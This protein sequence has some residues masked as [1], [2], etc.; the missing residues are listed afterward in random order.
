MVRV[1]AGKARGRKLRTIDSDSTKP[2]LD[3]VKEAMFSMIMPYL[4]C[5]DV[6]DLF[7]GNGALGIEALSR[8]ADRCVFNDKSR[9]CGRYIKEN[10]S[11]TGFE[12]ASEIHSADYREVIALLKKKKRKF[13]LILLDPPYG[14]EL[15][16]DALSCISSAGI[17]SGTEADEVCCVAV[18][19]HSAEDVLSER[20]GVFKKLKT[21]TYGTVAVSVYLAET[22]ADT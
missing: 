10:V 22:E 17:Y 16:G 12:N 8:G 20:Y 11:A 2:T 18:A 3:R 15:A 5:S 7:A 1:I 13:D 9:E 19:E 6:L 14:K 4:P 21:K